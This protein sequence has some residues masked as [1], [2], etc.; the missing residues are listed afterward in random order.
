MTGITL[1]IVGPET[2]VAPVWP[3]RGRFK[4]TYDLKSSTFNVWLRYFVWNFKGN[5]WNSTQNVLPIDWKMQILY[6]L[7]IL[8][9]LRFKSS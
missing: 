2:T 5:L 3:A 7:E 4:N 9:A 6:N 1:Y 8:R